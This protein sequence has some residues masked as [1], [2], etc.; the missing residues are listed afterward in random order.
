MDLNNYLLFSI[1]QN[2][3][4]L[5]PLIQIQFLLSNYS[6]STKLICL[7]RFLLTQLILTKV[8]WKLNHIS[9][10]MVAK[11]AE[12]ICVNQKLLKTFANWKNNNIRIF[13]ILEMAIMITV[14]LLI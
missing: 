3:I 8:Y 1:N 12:L 5:L 2:S 11:V 10:D 13:F 14:Q 4:A 6:R 7:K 9:L